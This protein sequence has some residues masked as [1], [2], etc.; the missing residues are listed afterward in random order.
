MRDPDSHPCTDPQD[1]DGEYGGTEL[2]PCGKCGA[3]RREQGLCEW[4]PG[5]AD[6]RSV[7]PWSLTCPT[8]AA[9]PGQRCRR[10]SGHAGQFVPMHAPRYQ[11]A[12]RM[13]RE[14]G[15]PWTRPD[16]H[17]LALGE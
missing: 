6:P 1:V 7:C 5:E 17:Q 14:A 13:D 9:K 3:C 12:E 16:P 15:V 10:P 8:C 11:E 2:V 4:C